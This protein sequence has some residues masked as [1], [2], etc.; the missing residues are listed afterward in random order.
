MIGQFKFI[1]Y[2]SC[3]SIIQLIQL[4]MNS[5]EIK[6]ASEAKTIT[7]LNL[8]IKVDIRNELKRGFPIKELKSRLGT[9]EVF[10]YVGHADEIL[11][12]LMNLNHT[13]R[14]YIQHTNCIK[15]FVMRRDEA[16]FSEL[17]WAADLTDL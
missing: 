9:A 2:C 11:S 14:A 4:K 10:S 12:I 6:T 5:K 15:G 13:S 1:R 3:S 17:E 8:P 7:Y 16:L